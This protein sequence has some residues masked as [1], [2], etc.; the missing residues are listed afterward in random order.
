MKKV[1]AVVVMAVSL[2]GLLTTLVYFGDPKDLS[3]MES[4]IQALTVLGVLAGGFIG[5]GALL[6]SWLWAIDVL[7]NDE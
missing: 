1:G 3:V 4:L 5:I 2:V 7:L 6:V